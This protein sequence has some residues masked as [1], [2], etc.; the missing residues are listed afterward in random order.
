MNS[1]RKNQLEIELKKMAEMSLQAKESLLI[2]EYLLKDE[3]DDYYQYEKR[4]NPFLYLSRFTYWKNAVIELSKLFLER[5]KYSL[6]KLI[7]KLR[8]DGD[9]SQLKTSEESINNWKTKIDDFKNEIKN[10][11]DQRDKV[12]A[13]EDDK[14]DKIFNNV[15]IEK[16]KILLALAFEVINEVR[17]SIDLYPMETNLSNSS[18]ISLK[19]IIERLVTERKNELNGYREIA[20]N[21]DLEDELPQN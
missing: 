2:V 13:H 16:L 6:L 10:L 5:E 18:V 19:S 20:K 1:T 11:K 14:D 17:K 4:M 9:Y 7:K 21:Y 8:K 15:S 3:D 12:Y